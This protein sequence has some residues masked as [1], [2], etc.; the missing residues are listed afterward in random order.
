ML[1][2]YPG[3]TYKGALPSTPANYMIQNSWLWD[4]HFPTFR[5]IFLKR[6]NQFCSTEYG[7]IVT[8]VSAK[9]WLMSWGLWPFVQPSTSLDTVSLMFLLKPFTFLHYY[10]K[11]DV[12]LSKHICIHAC[13]VFFDDDHSLNLKIL[14]M[15]HQPYVFLDQF[16]LSISIN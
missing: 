13:L 5:K 16:L 1:I 3:L 8:N 14:V 9:I 2:L 12:C 7:A 6:H 11:N 4:I 15:F 10:F